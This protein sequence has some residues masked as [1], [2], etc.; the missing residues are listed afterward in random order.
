MS[1]HITSRSV[2]TSGV[3]DEDIREIDRETAG[4]RTKLDPLTRAV[5]RAAREMTSDL[6]ISDETFE[7]L[8]RELD[9]ER[10]ID[11][12]ITIAF[13]NGVVRLLGALQID[14]EEEYLHYLDEFPL[15]ND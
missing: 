8:R 6:Q 15:P 3:S 12:V 11:L 7:T 5:L 14:V 13:Y 10:L 2:A 1:T 4:Q 9:S